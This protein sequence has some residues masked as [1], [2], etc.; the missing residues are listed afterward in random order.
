VVL[1]SHDRHM[2][3]LTA[4]RL[5]LVDGGTATEFTGTI[6]DYTDFILGKGPAKEKVSKADRKEDKKAAAAAREV[7]AKLK[8][9]VSDAEADLAKLEVVLSA[10]D[11]A[12]FDPGSAASEYAGLTM[13]ELSQR[14]GKIVA[15]Q[16][17]AEARWIKASEALE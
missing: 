9:E 7:Q 8:R 11:R 5:V 12:M 13:G 6:D 2:L 15:A 16:E 3:E 1:V 14:R 4:D 10:I 17:A